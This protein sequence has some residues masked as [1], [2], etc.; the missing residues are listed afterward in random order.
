MFSRISVIHLIEN[1]LRRDRLTVR[2]RLTGCA[3][4]AA[5]SNCV[6]IVAGWAPVG[7]Y[8]GKLNSLLFLELFPDNPKKCLASHLLVVDIEQLQIRLFMRLIEQNFIEIST[9]FKRKTYLLCAF[10][11]K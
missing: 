3:Q 10:I 9:P 8:L 7:Q 5:V 2:N 4:S 6:S 1:T 11:S